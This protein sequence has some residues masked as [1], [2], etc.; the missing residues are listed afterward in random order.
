MSNFLIKDDSDLE[1]YV[2]KIEHG[3]GIEASLM[4]DKIGEQC[5]A[6]GVFAS[7]GG[8]YFKDGMRAFF[9]YRDECQKKGKKWEYENGE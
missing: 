2:K 1:P 5:V 9:C 7:G 3:T 8:V 6:C 4:K